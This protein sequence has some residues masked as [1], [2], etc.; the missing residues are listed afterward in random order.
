MTG[1]G[2]AGPEPAAQRV[3]VVGASAAGLAV[4]ESLRRA[5]HSGPLTVLG[6]E[7]HP[8]YD[9]PPLSKQILAGQWE[10]GRL[11]LRRPEVLAALD[12]DLRLGTPAT[13]LDLAGRSVAAGGGRIP[14]DTLVIATGVSPRRLPGEGAHVLR[15]LDDA[16]RLRA[17]VKPGSTL[18]VVGAGFLGAEATAVARGIGAHVVLLEPAPVPLAHAVGD[19]VGEVIAQAHRDHGVDLR[20]GVNVLSVTR[21]GALTADGSIVEGDEVLVAVGSVPN[22]A[23][24]EGSGL[25]LG[26]GVHCDACGRAAPGVYAAGDV[27]RW[28]NPRYG[29]DMRIEHRTHAA[30]MG[31]AVAGNILDPGAPREIAPLPYFWSDQ[32]DLRIQSFGY[33]RG[34]KEMQIVH[35]DP[36]R[37]RFIAAYRR[38]DRLGGVLGIGVPPRALRPWRKAA[39]DGIAWDAL[40]SVEAVSPA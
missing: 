4:A 24:L 23:W 1:P 38:G 18:I 31:M 19:R 14:Y 5:G 22:T 17:R 12:L 32:Y 29:V 40:G 16:L 3:V 33:L 8:P 26:D 25:T 36:A 39:A 13:G 37:R 30:E 2:A 11:P 9:R 35:G 6:A 7:P 15:T 27:A 28:H 21:D 34:H 10:A 20:T